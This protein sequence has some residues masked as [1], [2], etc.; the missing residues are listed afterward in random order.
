M[1]R[2]VAVVTAV[3]LL[4]GGMVAA[5]THQAI[6]SA[7]TT[8][9]A[10]P[11][12]APA[13]STEL[14]A[15]LQRDLH[16]TAEQAKARLAIDAK[17]SGIEQKLRGGLGA[18][19]GGVW[20]TPGA[21][22]IV[23]AVTD[24]SKAAEVRAAGATP[25]VVKRSESQL[26]AAKSTLDNKAAGAPKS[27]AGWY[28]DVATNS[29]VVLAS[30]GGVDAAKSFV[31][32]SGVAADSVRVVASEEK[33][34]TLAYI[35]GGDAYYINNSARCSVG[36]PVVG[37]F[38]TAGHC[39]RPGAQTT[40]S[41]GTAQGTFQGSTFP[42]NDYAWVR[43]N[44][45]WTP[46]SLVSQ[47]NGAASVVMGSQ[48]A[49][50]GASICRSGSTTGWHCGTLQAKNSTVQYAQGTVSGLTRTDVCAEPGDS[51]G[52]FMWINQAQGVTSGGS[53]DCKSG[54]TTYFQPVNPILQAYGLQLVTS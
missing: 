49:P 29:V 22:E 37:G 54:G 13:A 2:K 27:V 41:N 11:K 28:V 20:L 10:K 9:A 18:R 4:T 1:P 14:L 17:A 24:E 31:T 53:G 44:S 12:P 19:F 50:V 48:E 42:G 3:A 7:D 34:R 36:F 21:N 30:A 6:A 32:T 5:F 38:V 26:A 15:A 40:G 35:S 33:P 52:S 46:R 47:W 8:P 39:G 23:V 51:G 45:G 16:L 25:K 43:V